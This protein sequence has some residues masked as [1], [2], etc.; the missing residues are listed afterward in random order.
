LN[1][2]G[3]AEI[4]AG[5]SGGILAG[6][7]IAGLA[8]A[9]LER[10]RYTGEHSEVVAE[11]TAQVAR[12]L[13][14][15]EREVERVRAAALLHDIGKVGIPDDILHKSRDLSDGEWHT[16]REHPVIGERIVRTIPG[17]GPVAR[18]VR[19]EHEYFD[20]SGYP[21]GLSGTEI[22]I[23]ARIILACDAYHAMTSDRPYRAALPHAEAIRELAEGAGTQ[24]DPQVTEVL[25][26]Y[27]FSS[28]VLS[29]N[30]AAA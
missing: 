18:I 27:L 2:G 30:G 1:G 24:F 13:G 19:H 4:R 14:L 21:D 12:S 6:D 29:A 28:R 25:I 15:G 23:G 3:R 8:E 16:M 22:P 5:E 10:D 9:L 11:L 17:L 20:G 26:G 7:T